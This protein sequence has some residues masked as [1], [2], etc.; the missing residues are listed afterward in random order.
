M[1][2]TLLAT[3]QSRRKTLKK[4]LKSKDKT[5]QRLRN[6]VAWLELQLTLHYAEDHTSEDDRE[7]ILIDDDCP[8]CEKLRKMLN[9]P[10]KLPL[11]PGL[12]DVHEN[13]F[14]RRT[15]TNAVIS[16]NGTVVTI[17]EEDVKLTIQ[18][19]HNSLSSDQQ[20][21]VEKVPHDD[22]GFFRGDFTGNTCCVFVVVMA[23]LLVSWI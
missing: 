20:G 4:R 1:K 14:D 18:P 8:K 13:Q 23:M 21:N 15:E 7:E 3:M 6:R 2:M 10:L 11:L 22:E 9:T 12:Q 19:S 17:N 16:D 5:I